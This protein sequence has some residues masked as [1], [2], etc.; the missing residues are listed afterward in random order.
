MSGRLA[1]ADAAQ[2]Q[3]R[4]PSIGDESIAQSGNYQRRG[5][6]RIDITV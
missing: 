2:T 4:R 1:P 3:G 5:E 6:R